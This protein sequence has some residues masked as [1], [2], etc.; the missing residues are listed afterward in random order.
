M[1]LL[2]HPVVARIAFSNSMLT[3]GPSCP[4]HIPK[5][6]LILRLVSDKPQETEPLIINLTAV[7]ETRTVSQNQWG[8]DGVCWWNER[9]KWDYSEKNSLQH[10]FYQLQ[11]PL[12]HVWDRITNAWM[13]DHCTIAEPQKRP[14]VTWLLRFIN[15][16]FFV[17]QYKIY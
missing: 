6:R 3:V 8:G 1:R 7:M 16:I 14:K 15:L 10:L 12:N 13:E 4:S 9:E 11:S 17:G 2:F 5:T